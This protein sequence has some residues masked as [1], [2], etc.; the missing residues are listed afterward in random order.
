MFSSC[1]P[2]SALVLGVKSGSGNLEDS[3]RPFSSWMPWT[4]DVFSYS[5]NAE[6][7]YAPVSSRT[8]NE[9]GVRTGEVSPDDGLALDDLAPLDEDRAAVE[10]VA[11]LPHDSGHLGVVERSCEDVG[12]DDGVW[13][14][15]EQVEKVERELGEE[16]SL[17]GDP[18]RF[19][20]QRRRVG[21]SG[22]GEL[23][24]FMMWSNAETLSVATK[25]SRS[26]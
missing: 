26:S 23:T 3:F 10:L 12:R 18:L 6:P 20:R 16:P 4:V 8:A 14:G 11:I 9:A 22:R 24:F 5:A 15:A 2:T 25:S 1:S 13:T 19:G 7:E 21:R 17:A